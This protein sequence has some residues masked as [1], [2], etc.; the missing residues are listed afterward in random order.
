MESFKIKITFMKEGKFMNILKLKNT[1][2]VRRL[3]LLFITLILCFS[4]V[5]CSKEKSDSIESNP[6]EQNQ[7]SDSADLIPQ[8]KKLDT[9]V[10]P[11][12]TVK[13]ITDVDMIDS[14]IKDQT[15]IGDLEKSKDNKGIHLI[16]KQDKELVSVPM[17]YP[18]ANWLS[19]QKKPVLFECIADYSKPAQES[20]P[21]LYGIADHYQDKLLV[22]VVDVTEAKDL[23][24][25]LELKYVPSFFVSKDLNVFQIATSFD[26][27]ANPSLIDNIE[28][29]LNKE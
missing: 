6:S 26:L 22:C 19:E 10:E 5:A 23:I 18:F 24:D 8:E 12:D 2:N 20:L 27:Y 3:S 15:E 21:Y 9:Q 11:I 7:E 25:M 14:I 28:Q 1:I 4:L 13:E 17:D 16:L 29:V